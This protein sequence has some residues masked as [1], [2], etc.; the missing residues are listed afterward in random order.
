[1]ELPTQ[2]EKPAEYIKPRA[3]FYNSIYDNPSDW[4]ELVGDRE[5]VYLSP[6]ADEE[7][8]EFNPETVY[9]IGGL[10]DGTINSM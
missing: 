2:S 9:I 8:T 5:L 4:E 1:M 7:I 10:V 6:D 3:T